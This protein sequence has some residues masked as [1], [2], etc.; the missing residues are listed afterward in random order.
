MV[1]VNFLQDQNS[2]IFFPTQIECLLSNDGI[3][4]VPMDKSPR[5]LDAEKVYEESTIKKI[6]FKK[7]ESSY[8]YVKI[9]AK[10]LGVLPKWHIGNKY[11]GRSWIF[12]DEIT[13]K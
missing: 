13:I 2:W 6:T 4:F 10:Q 5:F 1:N 3:S 12:I 9:I 11:D 8:R 7:P